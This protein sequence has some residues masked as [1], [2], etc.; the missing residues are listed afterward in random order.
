MHRVLTRYRLARLAHLDRATGRVIRR[1]EH[2]A[3][4]DLVH[5][6][7]K[8]LGNIPDGGG[9]KVLGRPTAA[10]TGRRAY[11]YLHTAVDDHSRLAYSEIL[12]DEKK[13]TAVGFWQRPTPSSP[14][15]GSPSGES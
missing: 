15:P 14:P 11:A 1:Y 3:P 9:H 6:D 5:V 2:A 8:K 12:T 10:R 7:I 13:E 4:G